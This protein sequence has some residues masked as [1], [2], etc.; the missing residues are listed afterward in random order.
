MSEVPHSDK[1]RHLASVNHRLADHRK[2]ASHSTLPPPPPGFDD[3][4]SFHSTLVRGGLLVV[5]VLIFLFVMGAL[6][7]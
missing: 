7:G 3:W 2:N 1:Y 5:A 6:G 4:D